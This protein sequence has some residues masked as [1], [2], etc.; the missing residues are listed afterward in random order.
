LIRWVMV[1]SEEVRNEVK[2]VKEVKV[3]KEKEEGT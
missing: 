3:K 1:S 2:E